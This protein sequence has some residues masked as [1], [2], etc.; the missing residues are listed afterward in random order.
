ML[1]SRNIARRLPSGPKFPYSTA[2][3]RRREPDVTERRPVDSVHPFIYYSYYTRVEL[4]STSLSFIRSP[5]QSIARTEDRSMHTAQ[6]SPLYCRPAY[7][8]L[9]SD[10]CAAQYKLSVMQLSST[11]TAYIGFSYSQAETNRSRGIGEPP[12]L[13]FS[14][15][16]RNGA[17]LLIANRIFKS[18]DNYSQSMPTIWQPMHQLL[19]LLMLTA[20]CYYATLP[21]EAALRITPHPSVFLSHPALIITQK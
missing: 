17:L 6:W 15:H 19:L 12:F 20:C 21:Q 10:Y 13:L 4:L 2:Q 18:A 8:Y 9:L 16:R 14:R 3:S 5:R 1:R 11:N 7:T